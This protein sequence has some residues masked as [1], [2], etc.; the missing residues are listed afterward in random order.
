MK[1][2]KTLIRKNLL[3]IEPCVHGGDVWT[4]ARRRG[5]RPEEIVDYSSSINPLGA[6]PTAIEAA[7]ASLTQTAVY[8]D[9][10]STMLREAIANHFGGINAENIIIGNGSTE[11]IYLFTEAFIQDGDLA[12]IPQPTFGEYA[13]AVKKAGGRVKPFTLPSN[14][15]VEPDMLIHEM[16]GAKIL[17]LCNPNN[18]TSI[19]MSQNEVT[20]VIEQALD[21][22]VLIFIDED[23]IE[24][25]ADEASASF[26]N[27]ADKYANLFVLR[28]FTKFHGLTGLRVGYGVAHEELV[29][30][31]SRVKMPWNVN[32]A[33]Q[34]AAEAALRDEAHQTRTRMLMRDERAFLARALSKIPGFKVYPADANFF[35]INVAETGYSAPELKERMLDY[36]ILIRDCSSINGLN[37]EYI[38]VAVR[39]HT[40]NMKLVEAFEK[41][42]QRKR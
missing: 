34:A 30:L 33:A 2:L 20:A 22:D 18:P 17:F 5:L 11:L 4:P 36:G 8:P 12:L 23:Y 32:C 15:K 31:L 19:L 9:S 24:F 6:S 28:S 35:L 25:V 3:E 39:T 37:A 16:A 40:Q 29:S 13:V 42:V 38:R 26:V 21:R 27:K 1:P 10:N 41:T 7:A 14:F